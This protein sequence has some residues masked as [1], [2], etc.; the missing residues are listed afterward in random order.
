M[1][2]QL[3]TR[4]AAARPAAEHSRAAAASSTVSSA[5]SRSAASRRWPPPPGL[6]TRRRPRP[7]GRVRSPGRP[8][9]RALVRITRSSSR[10]PTADMSTPLTSWRTTGSSPS[11]P[12]RPRPGHH[13]GRP[14]PAGHRPT[15][16]VGGHGLGLPEPGAREDDGRRQAIEQGDARPATATSP[17]ARRHSGPCG[18]ECPIDRPRSRGTAPA[19]P[20]TASG[21]RPHE[22]DAH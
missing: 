21:C 6:P 14:R 8:R 22:R 1:R 5:E 9:R 11:P 12:A 13:A 16:A 18:V 15:Q 17:E 3:V 7:A 2:A 10:P 19:I 20:R 4:P